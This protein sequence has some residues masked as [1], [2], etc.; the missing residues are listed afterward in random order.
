M[1]DLSLWLLLTFMLAL[2]AATAAPWMIY[3]AGACV[4]LMATRMAWLVIR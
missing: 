3:V 4:A 1:K 2:V